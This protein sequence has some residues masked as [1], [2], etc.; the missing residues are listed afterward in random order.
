MFFTYPISQKIISFFPFFIEEPSDA[1]VIENAR[2]NG[3]QDKSKIIY[4]FDQNQF[5]DK[6][7]NRRDYYHYPS[8]Y[9]LYYTVP[10]QRFYPL[11]HHYWLHK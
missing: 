3:E 4:I 8:L 5:Y 1:V 10:F 11:Y 6:E 2:F 9:S 7:K